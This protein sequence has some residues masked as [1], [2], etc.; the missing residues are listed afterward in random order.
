MEGRE[1]GVICFFDHVRN[2]GFVQ[3]EG[4]TGRENN[5]FV[6]L[7]AVKRSRLETLDKGDKISFRREESQRRP[8]TFE[9]QQ[10]AL[11]EKAAA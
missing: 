5:V 4:S 7:A 6:S 1:T 2:F 3:P 11:I 10:I 8:G 9:A